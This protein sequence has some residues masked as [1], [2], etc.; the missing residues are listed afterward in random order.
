M[1]W[2]SKAKEKHSI[3]R[4]EM[5][6]HEL[7]SLMSKAIVMSRKRTSIKTKTVNGITA[8]FVEEINK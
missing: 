8:Y 6:F 1:R 5:L 7:K 3:P 4:L 2:K